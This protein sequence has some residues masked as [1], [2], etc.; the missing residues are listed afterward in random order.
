MRIVIIGGVSAGV[1]AAIN[2]RKQDPKAEIII[3]EKDSFFSYMTSGM[4]YYIGGEIS[5]FSELT[6]HDTK[7]FEDKYQVK[8][9]LQCEVDR[10]DPELKE[11]SIKKLSTGESFLDHYDKLILAT[12]ST[13]FVPAIEGFTKEHV[14]TFRTLKDSKA[15]HDYITTNHPCCACIVG[16]GY[17]ALELAENL[18][19]LDIDVTILEKEHQILPNY[20]LDMAE[21]VEQELMEEQVRVIKNNSVIE[22]QKDHVILE[23][24]A[25]VEAQIVIFCTGIRPNTS[26][27][28]E[29]QLELGERDAIVIDEFMQTSREDIYA[30]GDCAL[31]YSPLLNRLIYHPMETVANKTG[32]IAGK[33]AAGGKVAYIGTIMTS[34]IKCFSYTVGMTGLT[35]KEAMREGIEIRVVKHVKIDKSLLFQGEGMVIKAVADAKTNQLLGVQIVGKN[36]VDKRLDIFAVLIQLRA[37]YRVISQLDLSYAPPYATARD[38]IHYTGLLLEQ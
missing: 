22:I 8:V 10:V 21:L 37:D 12:G 1:S 28:K 5:A 23:D 7:T 4:S 27:A 31:V 36:G 38:P 32:L 34:I 24:E 29:L 14:F 13:S 11:I 2:A 20:D 35:E 26:I 16:S 9:Q 33:N 6:P 17:T 25:L 19:L 15:I 18:T 3:Y 30:C